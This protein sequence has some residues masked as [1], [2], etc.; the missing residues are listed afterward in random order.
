MA[1]WFK[2]GVARQRADPISLGISPRACTILSNACM[3]LSKLLFLLLDR[4]KVHSVNDPATGPQD[5]CGSSLTCRGG[6]TVASMHMG[7]RAG[8]D[9]LIFFG[10]SGSSSVGPHR[11]CSPPQ[12]GMVRRWQLIIWDDSPLP[13]YQGGVWSTVLR[14]GGRSDVGLGLLRASPTSSCSHRTP[15][16]RPRSTSWVRARQGLHPRLGFGPG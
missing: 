13:Q 5:S 16:R 14:P 2:A 15:C 8:F 12:L 10:W 11:A 7:N 3:I 4:E 1:D 9:T 6:P